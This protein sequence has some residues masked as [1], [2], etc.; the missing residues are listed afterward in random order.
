MD[1]RGFAT[2]QHV[3]AVALALVFFT[4]LANLIVMQYV[5]GAVTG[6]LD[7]AVRIGARTEADPVGACE[8]RIADSIGAVLAG[9]VAAGI[10]TSCRL[11]GELVRAE[12]NGVLSG[13]LPAVPDVP[14]RRTALSP[15]EPFEVP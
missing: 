15:R 6:A 2:V 9:P 10:E 5:M 3:A 12:A 13:W 7:E 11:D 14:F 8:R 1:E 4:L